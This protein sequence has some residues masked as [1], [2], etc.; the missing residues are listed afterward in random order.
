MLFEPAAVRSR[1]AMTWY[2][3]LNRRRRGIAVGI[4]DGLATTLA[5]KPIQLICDGIECVSIIARPAVRASIGTAQGRGRF[6]QS[7]HARAKAVAVRTV[8][9]VRIGLVPIP[10]RSVGIAA[11]ASCF[12]VV[13]SRHILT[14]T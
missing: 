2:V 14:L 4:P 9:T 3:P 5:Q 7:L 13:P 12:A 1:H 8:C 6:S 10:L 11:A